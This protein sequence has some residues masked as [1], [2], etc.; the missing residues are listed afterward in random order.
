MKLASI[1]SILFSKN[2]TRELKLQEQPYIILIPKSLLDAVAIDTAPV[3]DLIYENKKLSLISISE[4][5]T[6]APPAKET[7]K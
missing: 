2:E 4:T 1:P 7:A 5:E 6:T 3:F